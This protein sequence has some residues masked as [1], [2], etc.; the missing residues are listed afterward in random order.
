MS[1][2][3]DYFFLNGKPTPPDN[4]WGVVTVLL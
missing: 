4:E 2:N 3:P 1:V